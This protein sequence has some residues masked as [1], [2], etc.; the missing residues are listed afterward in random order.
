RSDFQLYRWERT[1]GRQKRPV[2]MDGVIG[3]LEATGDLTPLMPYL[4]A[5]EWLHVGS[6]TSMGMGRY[7]LSVWGSERSPS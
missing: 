6:G 5:G 7:T 4:R 3:A 2:A 1:S